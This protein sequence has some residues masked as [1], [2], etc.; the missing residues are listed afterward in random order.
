MMIIRQ[1]QKRKGKLNLSLNLYILNV[2]IFKLPPEN[3]RPWTGHGCAGVGPPSGYQHQLNVCQLK[4]WTF[5]F[6][7]IYIFYHQQGYKLL[8]SMQ[9]TC[10]VA[11]IITYLNFDAFSVWRFISLICR[12][13]YFVKNVFFPTLPFL[14]LYFFICLTQT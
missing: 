14:S 9:A 2:N 3:M 7:L 13:L 5:Y 11:A 8:I 6:H 12:V 1:Q 4:T 10:V